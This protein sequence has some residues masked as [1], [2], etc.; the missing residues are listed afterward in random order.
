MHRLARPALLVIAC[1]LWMPLQARPDDIIRYRTPEGSIG[2]AQDASG[3]PPGATLIEAPKRA[4]RIQIQSATPP[5][6]GR[7]GWPKLTPEMLGMPPK[8]KPDPWGDVLRESNKRE[9]IEREDRRRAAQSIRKREKKLERLGQ[10]KKDA[11]TKMVVRYERGRA[12]TRRVDSV[13]CKHFR[14]EQKRARSEYE[15]HRADVDD[16]L[17]GDLDFELQKLDEND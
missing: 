16:Q 14:A 2:F 5:A 7:Q 3:V 1:L 6:T 8:T 10:Q 13:G 9:A 12:I 15:A 11:C 17:H 4:P